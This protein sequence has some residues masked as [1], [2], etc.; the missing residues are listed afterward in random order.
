MKT[1]EIGCA[2]ILVED[3][4]CGPMRELPREGQLLALDGMPVKAG[5]CAANVAIDLARQGL[6]VQVLG[7]LGQDEAANALQA[8]L[9]QQGVDC[10]QL[11]RSAAHPTSRTVILLVEGQDRRY[12]HV[13]GAN[14]ELTVAQISRPWI[15]QLKVFYL[16]GLF[17]MPGID[18][19]ELAELLKYARAAGVTTV[20]DVV[21]PPGFSARDRLIALLPHVDYFLPNDDESRLITELSDPVEQLRFFHSHG[22]RTVV[23]TRGKEGVI[24]GCDRQ[25]WRCGAYPAKVVDPSGSGDAFAAG[26]M[27]GIRR[28]MVLPDMLR[29]GSALGASATR[30]VGTTDG[31]FSADEADAFVAA[32]PLPVV[33]G[34]F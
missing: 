31:V 2:G 10:R 24:A 25:V 28:G 9:E 26:V 34:K 18:L 14:R 33:A 32:N 13:F 11:V 23:I 4:F 1:I 17:V 21:I 12:L 29:Y 22:A 8:R 19:S 5:G 16:G 6:A 7:C 3:T 27:A 30:A 15:A 20:V